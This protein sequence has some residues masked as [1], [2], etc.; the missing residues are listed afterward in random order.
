LMFQSANKQVLFKKIFQGEHPR[1]PNTHFPVLENAVLERSM[2]L[3][4]ISKFQITRNS[5][6]LLF[7]CFRP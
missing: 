3:M 7:I 6:I 2:W 4:L 5:L 1:T